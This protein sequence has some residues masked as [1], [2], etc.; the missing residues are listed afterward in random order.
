MRVTSPAVN[1]KPVNTQKAPGSASG[2]STEGASPVPS[3][4]LPGTGP[5]SGTITASLGASSSGIGKEATLSASPSAGPAQAP[6]SLA[7]DGRVAG[8]PPPA[9]PAPLQ[10]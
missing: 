1:P 6:V 9:P 5:P 4:Q 3:S 2:F 8:K 7:P 10:T